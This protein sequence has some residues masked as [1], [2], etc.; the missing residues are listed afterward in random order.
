MPKI[1]NSK[2]KL[3]NFLIIQN[4]WTQ[5]AL[6]S[7]VKELEDRSDILLSITVFLH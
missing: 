3:T 2:S 7:N 5:V 1:C 4:M 6:P